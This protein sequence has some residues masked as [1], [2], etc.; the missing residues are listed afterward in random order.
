[1]TNYENFYSGSVS[2][3]SPEYSEIFTGYRIAPGRIS[4]PTS[5][6]TADQIRE[7]SSRLSEG[8]KAV[9]L[10]PISPEVFEA[11]PK[12]HMAEI[13]RL[14][15][16]TGGEVS[17]HAPMIDPAGFTREG[18]SASEREQA[19]RHLTSVVE[20]VHALNPTGNVP[21]TIHASGTPGTE[22]ALPPPGARE[23]IVKG[24]MGE[25][26]MSRQQA[27]KESEKAFII[28]V[29]QETG[30]M[31]PIRR[32]QKVTPEH[33]N[34]YRWQAPIEIIDMINNGEWSSTLS[35][36]QQQKKMADD[37]ME[38]GMGA[39]QQL[40]YFKEEIKKADEKVHT[41]MK[42]R[43]FSRERI[44]SDTGFSDVA[45]AL[46]K[47]EEAPKIEEQMKAR[48]VDKLE[49]ADSFMR[50]VM[51]AGRT[52]YNQAYKFG[53]ENQRDIL[54]ASVQP[55]SEL[56]KKL[57]SGEINTQSF[58]VVPTS[59]IKEA[60][61]RDR[62]GNLVKK[63]ITEKS[64]ENFKRYVAAESAAVDQLVFHGFASVRPTTY[65]PIE[66][67]ATEKSTQ[68]LGDERNF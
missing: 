4:S 22:Y 59:D 65:K 34:E 36:M 26:G 37:L 25:R 56:N 41:F 64:L 7:V 68:T 46:K 35:R 9:E 28:A 2:S 44:L 57:S 45:E 53:T 38:Q 33:P 50:D 47:V 20:R 39:F 55:Y 32:E 27:E 3:M 18:W 14:T 1:M 17:V 19:E 67:F 42:D 6:Q 29:H 58:E 49:K 11:I 15:K 61:G 40:E 51:A 12:Q 60:A 63:E 62:N 52:A 54:K 21:V 43:G 5:I 48:A 30:Q 16:L 10:Q 31:I 23:Q 8:V 13:N 66:E 24:L